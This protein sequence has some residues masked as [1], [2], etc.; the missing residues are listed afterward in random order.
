MYTQFS[1]RAITNN[2]FITHFFL[3]HRQT[4][5]LQTHAHTP[6]QTHTHTHCK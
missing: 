3:Q 4:K 1:L 5:K 6:K 2:A